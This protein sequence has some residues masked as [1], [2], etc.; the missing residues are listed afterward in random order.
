MRAT[1]ANSSLGCG[2]T[3]QSVFSGANGYTI[4]NLPTGPYNITVTPPAAS[5]LNGASALGVLVRAGATVTKDFTLL[6]AVTGGIR[7]DIGL[8]GDSLA[9]LADVPKVGNA[10]QS[11]ENIDSDALWMP[12]GSLNPRTGNR[13]FVELSKAVGQLLSVQPAAKVATNPST[14]SLISA[15]TTGL[16]LDAQ[17]LARTQITSATAHGGKAKWLRKANAQL[18]NGLGLVTQ[19]KLEQA[20]QT[21]GKAWANAVISVSPKAFK[22]PGA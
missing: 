21:F 19:G 15:A 9:P 12:D 10:I 5:S 20:I 18:A 7:A 8:I 3:S 6:P 14:S 11:L 17:T 1:C 4:S 2:S 16:T 22:H 13:V